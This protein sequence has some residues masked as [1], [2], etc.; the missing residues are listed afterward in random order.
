VYALGVGY[1]SVVYLVM[2][3][4]ALSPAYALQVPVTEYDRVVA[5]AERALA[6]RTR[7]PHEPRGPW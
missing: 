4:V 7:M 1:L 6:A 3:A 5:A 2:V